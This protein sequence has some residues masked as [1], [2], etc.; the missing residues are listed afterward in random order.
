MRLIHLT[1]P[2]LT[3][4]NYWRPGLKAGK[5]WLSWLSWRRKRRFHH[6]RERLDA[7]VD[8]LTPFEPDLFAVSGDLCQIGLEQEM[9]EAAGWL[10]SLQAVAKVM[11][12]PGNH[13]LFANDSIASAHRH[14][15]EFF[16][17]SPDSSDWPTQL[18]FGPVSVIG[19]NSSIPTAPLLASGRIG[20]R[21]MKTL[22]SLLAQTGDRFRIVMLHHPPIPGLTNRRKALQNDEQ[23]TALLRTSG[24]ELVLYGHLHKNQRHEL[25]MHDGSALPVF[26]TA[27]ASSSSSNRPASARVFDILPLGD[28]IRTPRYSVKMKLLALDHELQIQTIDTSN[29]ET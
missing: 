4:L 27:S 9:I 11:L 19:L 20:E 10:K 23:L 7:L 24:A 14:W 29:W 26:C 2:H 13:D 21:A 25:T 17:F 8:Q 22:Q 12:V 5:R 3:D 18:D 15:S 6:Q 16:H 28:G 1:D